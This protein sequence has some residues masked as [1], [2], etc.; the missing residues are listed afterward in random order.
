[1]WGAGVVWGWT[2]GGAT[3][4]GRGEEAVTAWVGSPEDPTYRCGMDGGVCIW[5]SQELTHSPTARCQ[6][7]AEGGGGDDSLCAGLLPPVDGF[8][9]G[10]HPAASCFPL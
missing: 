5:D 4:G 9:G 6:V 1:M 10:R 2:D 3:G 7:E 8:R